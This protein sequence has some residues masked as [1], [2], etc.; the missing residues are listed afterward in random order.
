MLPFSHTVS[1]LSL[2]RDVAASLRLLATERD[3]VTLTA[4][5]SPV[6]RVMEGLQTALSV[7]GYMVTG[8]ALVS[9]FPL[10]RGVLTLDSLLPGN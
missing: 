7:R 2:T 6:L 3:P 9:L 10:F 1:H 8:A 4:V 5:L